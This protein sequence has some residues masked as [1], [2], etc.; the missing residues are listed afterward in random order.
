LLKLTV[1]YRII[2]VISRERNKETEI[3]RSM[4]IDAR[5]ARCISQRFVSRN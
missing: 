1:L 2:L 3:R 5:E 4:R